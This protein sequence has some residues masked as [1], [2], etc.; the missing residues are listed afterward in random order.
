MAF[1]FPSF[2]CLLGALFLFPVCQAPAV[3]EGPRNFSPCLHTNFLTQSF[4]QAQE[5]KLNSFFPAK[6]EK[7]ILVQH[8]ILRLISNRKKQL[9]IHFC[10][11]MHAMDRCFFFRNYVID[12]R[13]P[14]FGKNKRPQKIFS[15]MHFE[16]FLDM[17]CGKGEKP[18]K[19]CLI[20]KLSKNRKFHW[21]P[22]RFNASGLST[23]RYEG[24]GVSF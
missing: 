1:A 11:E 14:C 6:K 4:L 15:K 8:S 2:F 16:E 18:Y 19:N 9:L 20:K 24:K 21:I 12:E 17:M 5:Q 3:Q 13:I 10:L 23:L 7:R 22:N